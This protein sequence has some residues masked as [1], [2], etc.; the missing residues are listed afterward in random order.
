MLKVTILGTA[1]STPTK[2]RNLPAMALDYDG[3]VLLFDC[4]EGTQRQCMYYSVNISRI[5]AIFLSHIHGDHTIGLAGLLR[6]LALNKRT[7]PVYIYIPQGFEKH[8]IALIGFDMALIPYK[9]IIKPIKSGTIYKGK[10]FQV[11][12]F[13][14]THTV[15]T[16]GFVFK[17]DDKIRF[18]K[19][20]IK[21]LGIKGSMFKELLK[22]K[23]IKIGKKTIRLSEVTFKEEGKKIAYATDTRPSASTVAAASGADVLIHES[24]YA[25]AEKKLARERHHSTATESATIAKKSRAKRLVLVHLSARYRT[26]EQI[27]KEARAVFHNT[28]VA[29]DGFVINL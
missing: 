26:P 1:G 9:L 18:L 29:K 11:S 14:L 17:E 16:Y 28:D 6:T 10:N 13:K 4:G 15:P 8:L 23:H 24:T 19:P 25:E 21:A 20:K 7:E 27:L 22:N 12:A 3:S 2:L 5:K